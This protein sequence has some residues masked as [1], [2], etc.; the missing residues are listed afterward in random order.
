MNKA[1]V[2]RLAEGCE[3][4][5]RKIDAYEIKEF[6]RYI[7]FYP[8]PP[9]AMPCCALGHVL[10]AAGFSKEDVGVEG[11]ALALDTL[12]ETHGK[13]SPHLAGIGR[14][15]TTAN[16][17]T[18]CPEDRPAFV[19]DRIIELGRALRSLEASL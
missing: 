12:L 4:V 15:I 5:V 14:S 11:P 9:P 8:D 2:T 19:R 18:H 13:L 10:A 17:F 6:G 7:L 1:N 16:D 3:A